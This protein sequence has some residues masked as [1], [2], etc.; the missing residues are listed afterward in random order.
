VDHP[1]KGL[2]PYLNDKYVKGFYGD[3]MFNLKTIADALL[4]LASALPVL[5]SALVVLASALLVLC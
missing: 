2:P 5:A 4:V 1:T 3:A